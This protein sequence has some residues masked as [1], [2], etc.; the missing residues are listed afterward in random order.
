MDDKELKEFLSLEWQ[1][2]L[3]QAQDRHFQLAL[4]VIAELSAAIRESRPVRENY[5]E[6]LELMLWL[7]SALDARNTIDFA[8]DFSKLKRGK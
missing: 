7:K 8:R 2:A 4:E 3:R 1:D 6:G 5:R